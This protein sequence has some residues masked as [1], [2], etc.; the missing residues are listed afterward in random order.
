MMRHRLDE[1][2]IKLAIDL[3]CVRRGLG[4]VEDIRFAAN[5]G[6]VIAYAKTEDSVSL[7]DLHPERMAAAE[8]FRECVCFDPAVWTAASA[9]QAAF[10][11]WGKARGQRV[12]IRAYPPALRELGCYRHFKW[13]RDRQM[14]VWIGCELTTS[15]LEFAAK[16]G[17]R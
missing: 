14:A 1:G 10:R 17:A 8:F 15:G 2:D 9:M 6:R 11:A 3:L 12:S 5:N 16:G 4:H 13:P 7:R